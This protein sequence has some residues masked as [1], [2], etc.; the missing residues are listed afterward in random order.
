MHSDE[1]TFQLSTIKNDSR[2]CLEKHLPNLKEKYSAMQS[3]FEKIARLEILVTR[4]KHDV[5][6]V[7]KQL[8]Q[9]ENSAPSIDQTMQPLRALMKPSFI[10]VS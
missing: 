9:A 7:D 2:I 6:K 5:D 1:L 8:T 10:F 4:I 3:T